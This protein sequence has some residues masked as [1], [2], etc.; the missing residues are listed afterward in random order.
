[1]SKPFSPFNRFHHVVIGVT[2]PTTAATAWSRL[3]DMP[4][5]GAEHSRF[6]VGDGWVEFT[7]VDPTHTGVTRVVVEVDD[8]KTVVTQ[9]AESGIPVW[10][11]G[12][13]AVLKI[14]GVELEL[15]TQTA[16][17]LT[18]HSPFVRFH[19]VVVAVQNDDGA[20]DLW[21]SAFSFTPAPE[22]PRGAIMRHHVPVG[23]AWFGL[24]STGTDSNALRKYLDRR[25]EGVYGLAFVVSDRA[26][27]KASVT[28]A[29][30]RVLGDV[31][32]PQMFVH[33]ASTHGV[34]L[35]IASEWPTPSVEA[36]QDA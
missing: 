29:G 4:T 32:D 28:V 23:N 10:H 20:I 11:R 22:G 12:D 7:K 36:E 6:A 26:T 24:T 34:L 9:A 19:H 5:P 31:T 13:N 16:S 18:M 1:M 35:E 30:G 27:L 8:V 25:G 21:R 15:C 17:E 2:D 14:S 3:F 33:P